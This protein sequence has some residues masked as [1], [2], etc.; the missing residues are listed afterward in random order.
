MTE[1]PEKVFFDP[2]NPEL[3]FLVGSKLSAMDIEQLIQILVGNRDVFAW[4][5]YDAPGVSPDL[6]CHSLNIGPEHKPIVQKRQKLAPERAAIV[7]E[8][9]ERLLASEA[10]WEVQYLVWLSNT[11]V[12]KKKNGKWRV[13]INFIDLN[14]TCPKDPFPLPRIDQLVDSALG[15]A[16]LSFLDA[17]QGYHQIPMNV[18]D[19]D[20]TAFITPRGTYCYKVMPFGLKNA[21]ATYQRI[22]TKMFGHMIGKTVE[23]YIDDMLVKSLREENHV[24]DLL[25]VFDILRESCLRLNASKCMF[26]L[27][28]GKFLGHMVSRRGIEANPDQIAGLIDLAEPRNIKQ[29]Q[30]LTDM[31]ATLGRFISKSANKCKP[32]FRLLGKRSKF[33]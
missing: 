28:S 5:V 21:G 14:K 24:A 7:L 2:S 29:V 8:E 9:V 20:K 25:Q 10:I 22:V 33:L 18:T 32:F 30:C 6:A 27:S 3:F 16:R 15:H 26:G 4:S 31:V 12:V 13:G 19:Q 23:V 1:Q 17:F 11:V